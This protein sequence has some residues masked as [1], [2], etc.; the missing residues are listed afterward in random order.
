MTWASNHDASIEKL[1]RVQG[2]LTVEL[3]MVPRENFLT[4]VPSE[5]AAG[6]ERRN[7]DKYS[8]I[9][10]QDDKGRIIGLYNAERWFN[11]EAPDTLVGDDFSPLSEDYLIGADASIFDFLR[12]ADAHPTNLVIVGTQIAGLVSLSD[13]QELPVRAALFALVTSFEM[14]MGLMIKSTWPEP[15]GWM[16]FLSDG[17][18]EKL[19]TEI[20]TAKHE[21]IFTD[22]L[23]LTQFCDKGDIIRKAELLP[24]VT[25]LAARLKAMQVLRNKLAHANEYAVTPEQAKGV[26]TVVSDILFLKA[27]MLDPVHK[28]AAGS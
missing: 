4:C 25:H 16:C 8:F 11:S 20:Q 26:W 27:R 10:V 1:R 2:S 5:T 28:P 3:I 22:E 21:N 7:R 19:E 18:R 15:K 17:R 23:V 24:E 9:P 13:I 12:Q 6:L 14:A